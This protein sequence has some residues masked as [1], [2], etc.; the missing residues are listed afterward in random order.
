[1]EKVQGEQ[2]YKFRIG[3]ISNNLFRNINLKQ[4]EC[5]LGVFA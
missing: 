1:M 4:S 2:L 3:K 5:N